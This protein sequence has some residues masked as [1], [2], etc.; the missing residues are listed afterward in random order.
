MWIFFLNTDTL[1]VVQYIN[2]LDSASFL[3]NANNLLVLVT[4]RRDQIP[5]Y[6]IKIRKTVTIWIESIL[7]ILMTESLYIFLH[8]YFLVCHL[9][10]LIS[11]LVKPYSPSCMTFWGPVIHLEYGVV[12]SADLFKLQEKPN[13]I[14]S[15]SWESVSANSPLWLDV[16]YFG[17]LKSL[18][19]YESSL[20]QTVLFICG[21]S[22]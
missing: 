5:L 19:L 14:F 20:C 11:L 4:Y 12:Y 21:L 9:H 1:V 13:T 2:F 7:S 22:E 3:E 17:K 18:R 10:L 6:R 16:D 8:S 15:H